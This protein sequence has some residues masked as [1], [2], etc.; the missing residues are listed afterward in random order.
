MKELEVK[1]VFCSQ[2]GAEIID[3]A[4]FCKGCGTTTQKSE[5]I[6]NVA[7]DTE[8]QSE[9]NIKDSSDPPVQVEAEPITNIVAESNNVTETSPAMQ[10]LQETPTNDIAVPAKVN[11]GLRS[12]LSKVGRVLIV[13]SLILLFLSSFLKLSIN[14]IILVGGVAIGIILSA[15][16]LKRPLGISKILELGVAVVLLV[17]AIIYVFNSSGVHDRYV[18]I[19]RDGVLNNYP[20]KTVGRAFDDFMGNPKWESGVAKDGT[21]FVNVKGKIMYADKEAEAVV[22]FMVDYDKGTFEINGFEINGVP[23]NIL[24]LWALLE[25][26][27]GES[28]DNSSNNALDTTDISLSRTY[29]NEEHGIT[30]KYPSDWIVSDFPMSTLEIISIYD[31]DG[32]KIT[33][34]ENYYLPF[35]LSSGDEALIEAAVNEFEFSSNE[36]VSFDNVVMNGHSMISLIYISDNGVHGR[37]CFFNF[38]YSVGDMGYH[39][40]F[41]IPLNEADNY[42]AVFEAMMNSYTV[43]YIESTEPVVS[44]VISEIISKPTFDAVAVLKDLYVAPDITYSDLFSFDANAKWEEYID[45]DENYRVQVTI[46]Y[47]DYEDSYNFWV[48]WEN[49]QYHAVL[50]FIEFSHGPTIYGSDAQLELE[51]VVKV[52]MEIF[53]I[54]QTEDSAPEMNESVSIFDII[55]GHWYQLDYGEKYDEYNNRITFKDNG[56]FDFRINLLYGMATI[57]GKWQIQGRGETMSIYCE[58]TNGT[59]YPYIAD[60]IFDLYRIYENKLGYEGE[61]ISEIFSGAVFAK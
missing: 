54:E 23:Q 11:K 29:R 27:Y 13:I 35:E 5:N 37:A 25:K 44:E 34:S 32:A 53:F 33:V 15:L 6:S 43:T 31:G 4:K 56:T 45:D 48:Y 10:E 28:S 41:T 1:K 2:C 18:Q 55:N 26:M 8:K 17:A 7:N 16:N 20:N 49:G 39:I 21:R 58:V 38:F 40:A 24:T 52:Y 30:F 57:Y 36:F 3:N 12:K 19:V 22:Q 9:S 47:G 59:E 46:H 60:F 50:M 51:E 14:P 42:Q 61:P